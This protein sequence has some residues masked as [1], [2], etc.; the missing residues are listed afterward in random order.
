MSKTFGI[1]FGIV[2]FCL[3]FTL[4]FEIGNS[5]NDGYNVTVDSRY[6]ER[7]GFYSSVGG[8][9]QAGVLNISEKSPG[10]NEG[11]IGSAGEDMQVGGIRAM[12]QIFQA[13]NNFKKVIFG[14]NATDE[15]LASK[16][17]ID[18]RITGVVVACVIFT[19]ALLLIGAILRNRL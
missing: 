3:V 7:R 12:A 13:P 5:I 10:G 9:A 15:G 6:S 17:G 16:I 14:N 18:S 19:I 11:S 2:V 8:T 4:I 1:V